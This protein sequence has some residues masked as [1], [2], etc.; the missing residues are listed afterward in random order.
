ML[1]I[2]GI[3]LVLF[4]CAAFALKRLLLKTNRI[5][6]TR[7]IKRALSLLAERMEFTS[8]PLAELFEQ[9][10]K[11]DEAKDFFAMLMTGLKDGKN[12][13]LSEIWGEVLEKYATGESLSLEVVSV[14]SDVGSNLGKMS[15]KGE[16]EFLHIADNQLEKEISK[17][18]K[19]FE[20][21]SGALK[22]S[23]ILVG[24]LIV[25]LFL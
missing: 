11:E 18:E 23:G 21:N 20:K 16:L 9:L 5:E 14:L 3:I 13:S 25:I 22:S 6:K 12:R 24:I 8:R 10:S 1:T 15:P 17:L 2:I 4:A 7:Q 19:D